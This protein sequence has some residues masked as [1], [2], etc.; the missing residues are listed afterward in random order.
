MKKITVAIF[1]MLA[2]S[3]C[4][5]SY[6]SAGF[7]GGFSDTQLGPNLWKVSFVGNGYTHS[8]RAE[9]F[10]ML[11]SAELTL[12]HG[13]KYFAYVD[14]RTDTDFAAMSGYKGRITTVSRPSSVN[15]VMM[16]KENPGGTA[17]VYDAQFVCQSVG[18]RYDVVCKTKN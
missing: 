14:S 1:S 5:T 9:D 15:T 2:I 6:Q 7:S 12:T 18:A 3:G 4:A 10:A 11:R 17:V 16:F 13:F 8:T